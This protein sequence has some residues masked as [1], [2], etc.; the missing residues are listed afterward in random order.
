[1]PE[2]GETM[3]T[4]LT[5]AIYT[6]VSTREQAEEGYSLDA[7]ERLLTDYCKSHRYQIYKFTAMKA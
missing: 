2:G 7:Q 5:A 6:R 3:R 1:M 4:T